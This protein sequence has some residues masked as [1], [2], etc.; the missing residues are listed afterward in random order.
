MCILVS[1]V[2][3]AGLV[4]GIRLGKGIGPIACY[5]QLKTG[6]VFSRVL[7]VYAVSSS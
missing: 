5:N 2:L 4:G 1:A 6:Q 3:C 7:S